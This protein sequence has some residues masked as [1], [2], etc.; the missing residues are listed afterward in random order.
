MATIEVSY[1]DLMKLIGKKIPI[2]DLRDSGIL[3]VK[4]QIEDIKNG[5]MKI[6]VADTNRPDLWSA[7]G[8]ARELKG[9]Y[10][11]KSGLPKF[12]I[13]KG[14]TRLIVDKN[15]KDIRPLIA[16]AVIRDI[17]IDEEFLIQLIQLQEKIA[18]N[19]GRKRKEI[20]IGLYDFDRI[21]EPLHYKAMDTKTK[22][23]P[24]DFNKSLTLKQILEIHPKGIAYGH[25][26]KEHN[27]YPILVDSN[28]VIASMPPVINSIITGKVTTETKNLFLEVT[29]NNFEYINTA[30]LIMVAALHDRKG[31]VETISVINGNKK[32]VTPVFKNKS[33]NV[34]LDFI[35]QR[36]G[37]DLK[38]QDAINLLK[39]CRCDAVSSGNKIKVTYPAYRQDILH[40]ADIVE[41]VL[42]CYGYNNINP[43]YVKI[44]ATGSLRK[45]GMFSDK[46][47]YALTG[48]KAQE[49]LSYTLTNKDNLF[50][51]MNLV[52]SKVIEIE[53]PVSKTWSVFRTSII[54]SIMEFL[55]KNTNKDYPQQVF[56]IGNVI[57][58]D[59]K[60]ET[61]SKD[62]MTLAWALSDSKADFTRAKQVLDY[63]INHLGFKYNIEELEHESFISGRSGRIIIKGKKIGII[64]EVRP[65]VLINWNLEMPAAV[66]EIDLN[67]LHK[68][69]KKF[70]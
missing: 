63:L 52:E 40:Q 14:S 22:F 67:E 48:F 54:P 45:I 34:D 11:M 25:L 70:R 16:G 33:I 13:K 26:I 44:S 27:Q 42:I 35:N 65:E 1:E 5:I 43:E 36:T 10:N 4:G 21:K 18:D 66:F 46:I 68:L 59:N 29:G 32:T 3:Q 53:N 61:R 38:K 20:A 6:E 30:L 24:L 51:K 2:D 60:E 41:D 57:I 50:K 55:S 9:R 64:G 31:K 39:K 15:V 17:K 62:V 12:N 23:V 49:I 56:E 28:G 47:A 69:V 19:F 7:E 8:I 37:L 58:P